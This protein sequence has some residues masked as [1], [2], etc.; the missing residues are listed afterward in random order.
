[1]GRE[2]YRWR[3]MQRN[4]RTAIKALEGGPRP[5]NSTRPRKGQKA[6]HMRTAEQ[7]NLTGVSEG[8]DSPETEGQ[9]QKVSSG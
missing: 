7:H 5:P 3:K 1:M 8:G 6:S 4:G 9:T 2:D